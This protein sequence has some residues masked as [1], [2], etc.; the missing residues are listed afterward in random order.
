MSAHSATDTVTAV[1]QSLTSRRRRLALA[2]LGDGS[3]LTTEHGLAIRLAAV[4]QN[5]PPDD[6][7]EGE[8]E[9]VLATLHHT[10]LPRLADAGLIERHGDCVVLIGRDNLARL[11]LTDALDAWVADE[12]DDLDSVLRA[13]AH[14]RRRAALMAL[15]RD[16][17]TTLADLTARLGSTPEEREELRIELHHTHLPRLAAAG[18]IERDDE[19]ITFVEHPLIATLWV[20][21]DGDRLLDAGTIRTVPVER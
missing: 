5:K 16:G 9:E 19:R 17:P 21:V 13:L 8:R 1:F 7:A 14:E 2:I 12:P 15:D 4:E 11:G 3:G 18:L 6:V 10:H 20:G